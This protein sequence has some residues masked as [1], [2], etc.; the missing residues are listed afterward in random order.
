MGRKILI[1]LAVLLALAGAAFL[2]LTW[3]SPGC[4]PDHPDCV[5]AYR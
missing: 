1:G 2:A 3:L 5:I 4:P